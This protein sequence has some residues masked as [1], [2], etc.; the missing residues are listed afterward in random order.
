M[1]DTPATYGTLHAGDVV[2]GADDGAEWTVLQ[3]V[4]MDGLEIILARDGV[5]V[6]GRPSPYTP[7]SVVRRS[8]VSKEAAAYAALSGGFG[9]AELLGER[10][11]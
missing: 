9:S 3:V 8:D 10:W 2:Q 4:W 1:T 11:T 5:E 6:V 7:V